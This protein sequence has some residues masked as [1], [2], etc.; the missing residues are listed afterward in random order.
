MVLYLSLIT[1]FAV[2]IVLTPSI[3]RALNLLEA[4]NLCSVA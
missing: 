2:I 3:A 4:H 1:D